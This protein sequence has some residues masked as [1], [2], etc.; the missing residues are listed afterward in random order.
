MRCAA[1]SQPAPPRACA[2]RTAASRSPCAARRPGA[3]GS[4]PVRRTPAAR[5]AAC[6]GASSATDPGST[7]APRRATPGTMHCCSTSTA[8]RQ[9]ARTLRE[10]EFLGA[11][12]QVADAGTMHLDA[13]VVAVR[14]RCRQRD[15]R[16]AVAEADL[17]RA[18]RVAPEQ[19]RRGRAGS[20][21]GLDAVARPQ[22]APRALLRDGHASGAH[23][24]AADR[25][26]RCFVRSVGGTGSCC[27][28]LRILVGSESR[29]RES[30][31]GSGLRGP[32]CGRRAGSRRGTCPR[33]RACRSCRRRR[34]RPT[35]P[36]RRAPGSA[37]PAWSSTRQSTGR[38]AGR[39]CSCG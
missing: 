10:A 38:S 4:P 2:R 29:R 5:C 28:A 36:R 13:E 30:A 39:P 6:G 20:V 19:R 37:A 26:A 14:V 31:D 22:F 3:G 11:Q 32:R 8:S 7:A 33:A 24:E 18:R 34:S 25:A 35:R 1:A 15:Q 23:H 17:E 16:F 9:I 27:L 12:H 21:A